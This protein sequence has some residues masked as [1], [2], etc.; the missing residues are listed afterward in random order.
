MATVAG[1]R[2]CRPA[3]VHLLKSQPARFNKATAVPGHLHPQHAYLN[4]WEPISLV[5]RPVQA[6]GVRLVLTRTTAGTPPVDHYGNETAYSLAIANLNLAY[7]VTSAADLPRVGLDPASITTASSFASTND[8]MGSAV[9]YAVR[10]N[11]AD[12]IRTTPGRPV[13]GPEIRAAALPRRGGQLHAD[14]RDATG[15]AQIIDRI[16]IDRSMRARTVA[17]LLQRCAGG[18]LRPEQCRPAAVGDVTPGR[19]PRDGFL[20]G[21]LWKLRPRRARQ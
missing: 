21:D 12:L 17:V 19:L 2:Q 7:Q 15:A 6:Q 10:T 14:L 18:R 9:D 8:V 11:R 1:Y 13:T 5:F 16:F 3:V 20:H 4:H